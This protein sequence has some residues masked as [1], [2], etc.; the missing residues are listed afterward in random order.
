MLRVSLAIFADDGT[1]VGELQ[2][3]ALK[4]ARRAALLRTAPAATDSW[5]YETQWKPA[6]ESV[7]Q[8]LGRST[9]NE[10][11]QTVHTPYGGAEPAAAVIGDLLVAGFELGPVAEKARGVLDEP[12]AAEAY[13]TA[14]KV[15]AVP[16]RKSFGD[17]IFFRSAASV[18]RRLFGEDLQNEIEPAVKAK[19]LADG[20]REALSA[21]I[22]EAVRGK[23]PLLPCRFSE[24]LLANYI[25]KFRDGVA[26]GLGDL[27]A[28]MEK[29][30]ADLQTPLEASIRILAS[31]GVLD[32][33]AASVS[34]GLNKIAVLENALPSD[35]TPLPVEANAAEAV[36]QQS[37]AS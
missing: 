1:L 33:T 24:R 21:T 12:E 22:D 37:V 13:T 20:G 6:V 18:R 3:L 35:L 4:R 14:V 8:W 36:P 7:A 11:I 9:R 27:R 28:S 16:V 17:W 5:L 25:T 30:R 15:G 32:E 29:Q 34:E 2:G 10:L 31:L 23:F 19:R 26:L